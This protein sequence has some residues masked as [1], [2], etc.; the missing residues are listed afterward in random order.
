MATGSGKTLSM[1]LNYRQFLYYNH[2]SLDNILLI[3]PNE[4]LSEQHMREMHLSGIRSERFSSKESGLGLSGGGTVRVIEISKLV[5]EKKGGG[6]TVPVEA[7]EGNNLILVDEGHKGTHGRVWRGYRDKLGE[8][9]FTFEYSATFGQALSASGSD[10]LTEEYGKAIAFDYSYKYFYG[11]GFGKDFQVLNLREETTEDQTDALLLANL[12]SFYE[13]MRL[14][15]GQRAALKPYGIDQP[16]WVFVG[17]SVNV[18]YTEERQKR[19]DVLTV[20]RFL[21]RFLRNERSW[22][23][24]TIQRV[25]A[26]QSGLKDPDDRDVFA[27]RFKYLRASGP[28]PVSLY[29]SILHDVFHATA[30]GGLQLVDIKGSDGELGLR[31]AGQNDYFGLVYIGDTAAFK[32]LVEDDDSGI[33]QA[34]ETISGSLFS[35]LKVTDSRLNILVGAKKFIEGWDS[36]RVSN[37]GLLN[38]GQGEGSQIIQLFGRGVR[39]RGRNL[40]RGAESIGQLVTPP[41]T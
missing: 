13:Q 11:D 33:E 39:L 25:L 40:L 26:G 31:V 1:H 37:M 19:S 28:D 4:G 7:F 29:Q 41:R 10:D 6:V 36:W 2:E 34:E 9:G 8:T 38:I 14:F 15:H 23:V 27:D 35:Q 22:A 21:H 5:E 32:K 30:G 16:L 3:T 12:L 18:V 17:S 24:R 20:A